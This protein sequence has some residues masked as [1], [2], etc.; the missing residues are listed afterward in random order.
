VRQKQ[1]LLAHVG[2]RARA[3]K[4][5]LNTRVSTDG[6]TTD[7][8]RIELERVAAVRGWQIVHLYDDNGVSGA[9]GRQERKQFDAL[10]KAA[11][12]REFDMVGCLER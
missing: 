6:Q 8:Q 9:K 4:V 10:L 11:T 3:V 2:P 7:N 5:A 12:R 1:V